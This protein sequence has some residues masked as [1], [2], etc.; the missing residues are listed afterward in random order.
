ML[1]G[2]GQSGPIA[3]LGLKAYFSYHMTTSVGGV[4][5]GVRG[6]GCYSGSP[7]HPLTESWVDGY[8]SSGQVPPAHERVPIA[9]TSL[10]PTTVLWNFT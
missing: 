2:L 3:K 7:H 8:I 9:P 5:V 4:V 6:N 10:M 1:V